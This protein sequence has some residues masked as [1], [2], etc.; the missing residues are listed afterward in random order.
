MHPI[1]RTPKLR[2]IRTLRELDGIPVRIKYWVLGTPITMHL[3]LR[4]K[5]PICYICFHRPLGVRLGCGDGTGD[6][7]GIVGLVGETEGTS[8]G[9][10]G[11]GTLD[12]ATVGKWLGV[13]V[14]CSVGKRVG[15]AEGDLV[16]GA[17]D[18]DAD[19]NESSTC[20]T[21]P[22]V[23]RFGNV[24]AAPSV[25]TFWLSESPNSPVDG[26]RTCA[27]IAQKHVSLFRMYPKFRCFVWMSMGWSSSR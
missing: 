14:G 4:T 15:D 9:G 6:S 3:T 20:K 8:E 26:V 18:G 2:V 5:N 23:T 7:V 16:D 25:S 22:I 12:L 13:G 21:M 19:G 27:L 10:S 1:I 17:I 11:E 24:E